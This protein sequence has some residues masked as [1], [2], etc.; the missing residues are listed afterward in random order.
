MPLPHPWT[1]ERYDYN[2]GFPVTLQPEL[3]MMAASNAVREKSE[4]WEKIKD[5]ELVLDYR[6]DFEYQNY[7]AHYEKRITEEQLDYVFKELDWYAQ[8]VQDQLDRGITAPIEVGIEG[9][10]RSDGL[11]PEELKT[12]LLACVEKL[13]NRPDHLKDW[14]PG[15]NKQVLDLLHPSLFPFVAGRTRVMEKEAIPALDS[16]GGGEVM[17]EA[18]RARDLRPSF[19]S[20]KFQWIPTD[21]DVSSDGKVK[22]KSYINNL[23][24]V[25]HKEMYSI[26]EEILGM[27]L[28]MFEEVLAEMEVFETREHKLTADPFTWYGEEPNFMDMDEI[29]W[30]QQHYPKPL[31]IPEFV[32]KKD[33]ARYNLTTGRPLQVI[34]KLANI[35]L[36]PEH[37][38]YEGGSWHVEG[39]ANENIVATG[40]YY[41]QSENI[42]ESRLN[43]RIQVKE[44]E[45]RQFDANGVLKM[46]GLWDEEPLIQYLD[47]IVTKQDRCIVFPNI[48]QHRVQPFQLQDP[49]K[50]GYRKILVFFL[51]N[52]EVPILST[53][54][55]PPQQKDW[56]LH[57]DSLTEVARR[58]PPELVQEVEAL[59]D[60]PMDLEEAKMHR[61]ELMK[62][63]KYF[64]KTKN[65]EMFERPF[66][67]CEH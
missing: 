10:R 17:K 16:I 58:L 41:Y 65:E 3:N 60:W 19:Y 49:T 23:H 11:I 38:K 30:F 7:R 51:V 52:P 62:E 6:F 40:I 45:Y 53:T 31:A 50:P 66:S 63:R 9:T 33:L 47:G 61:L 39:M 27:F 13:E 20:K 48:Y 43:F 24:P 21:F 22:A 26:L 8:K 28:P 29:A 1:G 15:S 18:P 67:L 57:N 2:V 44:P 5:T 46:Y 42:T 56:S 32:P 4:W 35:E 25:E 34:V 37:P 59:L 36:T 14:H 54:H 64:V 12:R 55:V